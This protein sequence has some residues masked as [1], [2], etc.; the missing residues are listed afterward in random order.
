MFPV[1]VN[2][3]RL[4]LRRERGGNC[5]GTLQADGF[6]GFNRRENLADHIPTKCAGT[7]ASLYMV[8][9]ANEGCTKSAFC[10]RAISSTWQFFRPFN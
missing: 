10:P 7:Q 2:S 6:S 1:V 5:H 9:A 3:R 4:R 8:V